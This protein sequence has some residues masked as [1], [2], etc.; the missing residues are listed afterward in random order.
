MRSMLLLMRIT[1]ENGVCPHSV[2]EVSNWRRR[3]HPLQIHTIGGCVAEGG[4]LFLHFSFKNVLQFIPPEHISV[5]KVSYKPFLLFCIK[6][7]DELKAG[8]SNISSETE[9]E[10]L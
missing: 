8:Q 9:F 4:S 3:E 1:P 5:G 6:L 10:V 2:C 7:G